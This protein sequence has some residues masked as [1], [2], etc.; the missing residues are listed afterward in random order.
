MNEVTAIHHVSLTVTDLDRSVAWYSELF[1]LARVMDEQHDNGHAVVLV[2]PHTNVFIG[3]HAHTGT[4]PG[5]FAE[6]TVGLDHVALTVGDRS[7]LETWGRRLDQ[8]RVEHSEIKD[9]PY[10]SILTLRDPDN[11]QLEL[12]APPPA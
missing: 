5:R 4:G 12:Y 9:R 6:T 11:I 10:G 1:G 8:H 2:Q 3:L 7:V